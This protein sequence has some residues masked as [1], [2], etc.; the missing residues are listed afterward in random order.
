MKNKLILLLVTT[1]FSFGFCQTKSPK[2]IV[3]GDDMG[4][5]HSGNLALIQSYKEGIETSIEVIVPAP[6][7][8]EAIKML[9]EN[10]NIDVGIHLAITSEW[11]NVK[12]RP[13]SD[14]PSL[15]NEDGYFHPMVFTNPNYPKESISENEWKIED[16]EK[17]FRAQIE[18]GLK[19]IP[20]V[21]HISGHM[22]C[23]NLSEAVHDMTK[24][25]AKEYGLLY[26]LSKFN[27]E[28]PK[29]D[30][31][32]KT[33]EGRL[34]SFLD[35]LDTLQPNKTYIYVEHPGIDNQELQAISHIGYEDVAKHRQDVTSIFTSKIVKDKILEKGIKLIS[36]KDI[37]K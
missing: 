26:D 29:Y 1:C 34:K 35:M 11:D 10:P 6:W 5:S 27:V 28:R 17:E 25:L 14:C 3:R 15:K 24:K 32:P 9:K 8:P 37:I 18:L 22:G 20:Q 36:Y 33:Y 12:W 7:F 23:S 30:A 21:S 31:T 16:V 2:L 13:I 19:H 4:Y